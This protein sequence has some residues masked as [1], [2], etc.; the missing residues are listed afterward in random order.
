MSEANGAGSGKRERP[1]RR[2]LLKLVIATV[3]L[4]ALVGAWVWL[5]GEA[6]RTEFPMKEVPIPDDVSTAIMYQGLHPKPFAEV[7]R[8]PQFTSARPG[9]GEFT[10]ENAG[11]PGQEGTYYF[12]VDEA[13]G[14]GVGYDTVYLDANGDLDLTDDKPAK[15]HTPSARPASGE[16]SFDSI[17]IPAAGDNG[18][19]IA[20]APRMT[21]FGDGTYGI[22]FLPATVREG[23][24]RIEGRTYTITLT[25]T[26]N[27]S[28][29]YDLPRTSLG[30]YRPD[31]AIRLGR[32]TL[33]YISPPELR[34]D[35]ED[36]VLSAR[37]VVQLLDD[38]G[39]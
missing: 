35:V 13:G 25:R 38:G 23:R 27:A 21:A 37:H 16:T 19:D 14:T 3:V 24:V 39:G 36:D 28:S 32:Q 22:R 2:M 5:G 18:K 1:K 15:I 4:A 17:T 8:Y 9:F 30:L 29:R 7:K 31:S 10:I 34:G 20:V 33:W 11:S 12:A 26:D 6:G